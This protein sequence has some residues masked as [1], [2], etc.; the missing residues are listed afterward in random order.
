MFKQQLNK[1]KAFVFDVDGVLT[2]S[3]VLVL[4]NGEFARTMSTRDGFAL[5]L[6]KKKG[7]H[8]C[9]ITAGT[10]NAILNRMEN[11]GINDVHITVRDKV[12]VLTK[13]MEDNGLSADEVLYMG[14]DLPDYKA[15]QVAGV[16]TCPLDA[17]DQ[18]KALCHYIS[19]IAGGKGCVRDVIEQT[20][21]LQKSWPLDGNY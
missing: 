14:D 3:D 21:R 18:I 15:I 19:D 6:A 17:V 8:V 16:R 11:L 7:Y 2:N 5:M 12:A 1:V 13:F 9:I 10:S 4:N 20:M